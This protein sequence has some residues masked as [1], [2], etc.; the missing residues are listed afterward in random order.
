M[1]ELSDISVERIKIESSLMDFTTMKEY[2]INR[3]HLLHLRKKVKSTI[4]STL[5]NIF[6]F[7]MGTGTDGEDDQPSGSDTTDEE[8][9]RHES[10]LSDD[11]HIQGD[12]LPE[13]NGAD[14]PE[15]H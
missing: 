4:S 12:N 8:E 13:V 11:S 10:Q 6:P 7:S 3:S 5:D 9:E 1:L 15:Y 14:I 2:L